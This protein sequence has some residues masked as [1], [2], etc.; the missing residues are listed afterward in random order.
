M[1]AIINGGRRN[2]V[3]QR[4]KTRSKDWSARCGQKKNERACVS[5]LQHL[6]PPTE[7]T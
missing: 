4:R 2:S 1:T 3:S 6:G 7:Q 5:G